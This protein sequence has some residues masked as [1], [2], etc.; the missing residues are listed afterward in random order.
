MKDLSEY[1]E[2]KLVDLLGMGSSGRPKYKAKTAEDGEEFFVESLKITLSKIVETEREYYLAGHSFGGFI[3]A[4]YAVKY[5]SDKLLKLLLISPVGVPKKPENYDHN[6]FVGDL[7]SSV[8]RAGGKIMMKLWDKNY[9]PISL[10][11][12]GGSLTTSAFLKAYINDRMEG[13]KSALEV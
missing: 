6:D 11:R 12:M 3:A 4:K 2:I 1:F 13:V 10:L 7:N 9:S 8:K 5:P